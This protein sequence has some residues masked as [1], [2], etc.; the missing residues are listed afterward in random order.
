MKSSVF[1]FLVFASLTYSVDS[2]SQIFHP[3]EVERAARECRK[4]VRGPKGKSLIDDYVL[5]STNYENC[6]SAYA[7]EYRRFG[8]CWENE[9][10]RSFFANFKCKNGRAQLIE[11]KFTNGLW[12]R[13]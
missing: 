12:F 10:P 11:V 6:L 3:I 8:I 5:N 13:D 7:I 2:L 4:E 9:V 1:C